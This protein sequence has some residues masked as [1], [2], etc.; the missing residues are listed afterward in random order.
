LLNNW[1]C[2]NGVYLSTLNL[3]F[4]TCENVTKRSE[5]TKGGKKNSLSYRELLEI[6]L[7]K[8]LLIR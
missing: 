5:I 2:Q 8:F 1:T 6:N 3:K 7:T 4:K